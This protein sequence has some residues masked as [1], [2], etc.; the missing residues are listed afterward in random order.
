[1]NKN[2]VK[3]ELLLLEDELYASRKL[4]KETE[5]HL[6]NVSWSLTALIESLESEQATPNSSGVASQSYEHSYIQEDQYI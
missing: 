1:M 6:A 5:R 2:S 3:N 4:G